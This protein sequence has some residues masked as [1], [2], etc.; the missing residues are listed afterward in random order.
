MVHMK[1]YLLSS[2]MGL[3]PLLAFAIVTEATAHPCAEV[4]RIYYCL[5]EPYIPFQVASSGCSRDEPFIIEEFQ[6]ENEGQC[7]DICESFAEI[8]ALGCSFSMWEEKSVLGGKCTLYREPFAD[9]IAHCKQL[10]GPPDISGCSVEDP[11]ESSCEG[12]R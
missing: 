6:L 8:G 11:V 1:W 10:S 3:L 4:E 2:S 9:Y 5:F 7:R 12:V